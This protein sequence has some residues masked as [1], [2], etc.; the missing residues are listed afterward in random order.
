MYY[1]SWIQYF[2]ETENRQYQ[3]LKEDKKDI[4]KKDVENNKKL[5]TRRDRAENNE[6]TSASGNTT[7]TNNICIYLR[8]NTKF[9]KQFVLNGTYIIFVNNAFHL[10]TFLLSVLQFEKV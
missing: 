6:H 5:K 1:S 3:G 8:S 10:F 7:I 2:R 4:K 9:C